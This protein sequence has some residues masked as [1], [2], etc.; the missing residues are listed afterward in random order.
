MTPFFPITAAVKNFW[1]RATGHACDEETVRLIREISAPMRSRSREEIA[2]QVSELR[3]A[4]DNGAT[5]TEHSILGPAFA[6]AIEASR[7][8]IG[9]ELYDVQILAGLALSRRCIAEMQTGEG[10]TYS[11][12]CPALVH[13]LAGKGV[14]VMTVNEYLAERDFEMLQPVYQ[15]LGMTVGLLRSQ[16]STADKR[17]AYDCEVTYGP[18]YEFGFDYLRDQAAL[19]Q[20]PTP[21]LGE[22]IRS[23]LRGDEDKPLER[24]QRGHAVAIL[25]EA[26]S[27]L[28]DEATTPLV[29]SGDVARPAEAP[30]VYMQAAGVAA[31]LTAESDFIIDGAKRSLN[32]TKNGNEQIRQMAEYIPTKGLRRPWQMYV[33][34]NLTRIQNDNAEHGAD[35][36]KVV[37]DEFDTL[38]KGIGD[39]FLLI[40]GRSE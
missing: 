40:E 36:R 34:Q 13:A 27:V 26:D 32:L 25:D 21:G 23:L 22:G 8:A 11:V 2:R 5:P 17:A 15:F 14:H 33:E 1:L 7:R 30:L 12:I 35:R 10:K 20:K 4:V 28:I 3:S 31:A 16:D 6:L 39:E 24:R 9:I 38:L 29:L 18:G 19:I 37:E